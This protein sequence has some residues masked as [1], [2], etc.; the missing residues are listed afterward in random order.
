MS[1]FIEKG[2]SRT[3]RVSSVSDD[4]LE[5]VRQTFVSHSMP[6]SVGKLTAREAEGALVHALVRM[7]QRAAS[8]DAGACIGA[9]DLVHDL[10]GQDLLLLRLPGG[11]VIGVGMDTKAAPTDH[12]LLDVFDAFEAGRQADAQPFDGRPD[13]Y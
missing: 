9:C 13:V 7:V 1:D 11:V 8:R 4:F 5:R 12:G 10:S 6:P 3:V 2:S